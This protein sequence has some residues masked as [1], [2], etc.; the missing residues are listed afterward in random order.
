[1]HSFFHLFKIPIQPKSLR[2]EITKHLKLVQMASI[3]VITL[4]KSVDRARTDEKKTNN[5][6]SR[7][8]TTLILLSL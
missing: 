4:H 1:M 8:I 6:I 5:N 2:E 3:A 7:E